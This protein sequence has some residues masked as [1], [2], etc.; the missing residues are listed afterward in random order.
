[1]A[2]DNTF[3]TFCELF[4]S[5]N[6]KKE[7][8]PKEIQ[9]IFNDASYSIVRKEYGERLGSIIVKNAGNIHLKMLTYTGIQDTYSD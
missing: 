4:N 2:E 7:Y 5:V 8:V 3:T 9:P 1:M 6:E